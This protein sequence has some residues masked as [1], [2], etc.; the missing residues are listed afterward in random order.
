MVSI[1]HKKYCEKT[2]CPRTGLD[3]TRTENIE[4]SRL[5]TGQ[6][7]VLGQDWTGQKILKFP[8][9]GQDRYLS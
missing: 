8:A 9:S 3:R 5:R 4:I 2:L 6:I 7:P 1:I